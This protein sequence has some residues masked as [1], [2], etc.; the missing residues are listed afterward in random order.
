MKKQYKTYLL[1][2]IVLLVWGMI[3]FQFLRAIN[4]SVPTPDAATSYEK[5][6]PKRTK[7]RDTFSIL[8]AYRD[9]FLGILETPKVESKKKDIKPSKKDVPKK[10]IVYTGFVT[11]NANHQKI[12]FVT[13]KGQQYMMGLN[14]VMQE[15]KLVSGTKSQIKVSY[16]GISET[17]SLNQ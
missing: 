4:P 9:P 10:N 14:D 5:F 8:A 11:D 7:I 13:I 12:F 3:G 17:V 15:V 2:V 6:N 1:L 16:N